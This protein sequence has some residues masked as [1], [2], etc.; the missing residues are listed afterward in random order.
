MFLQLTLSEKTHT[1][2]GH[3]GIYKMIIITPQ[4][5]WL[6]INKNI[7]NYAKHYHTCK[8]NKKYKQKRFGI[9][10][11]MPLTEKPFEYMVLD[12]VGGFNYY[13]STKKYLHLVA[14]HVTQYAWEFPSKKCNY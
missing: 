2:F 12:T 9:L 11:Q 8:I 14:D 6:N 1:Q 10:Q 13:N 7:E 4:Y 3:P 5:Y